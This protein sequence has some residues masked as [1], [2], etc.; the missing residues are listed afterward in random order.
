ML[1]DLIDTIETLKER[2]KEYRSYFEVAAP[3]ARTRVSLIDPLLQALEWDVANPRLVEIEPIVATGRADYALLRENGEPVLLLE[4]KRLSDTSAH[5]GQLASYVVGENMKRSVK[6]PYCGITNG[7]RWQVFDVFT[8][9]CVLDVSVDRENPR[10]CAVKLLGLW[11]P[12][13][14]EAVLEPVA[15]LTPQLVGGE[16]EGH[17][18]GPR[19]QNPIPRSPGPIS[20]SI[21]EEGN[22]QWTPLD[23]D[24]M[25][26]SRP[27]QP[28][29]IR[30]PD[31]SISKVGSWAS[32]LVTTV[33]WLFD[34]G[35]LNREEM[36]FSV[37]GTR[38]SVSVDGRHPDGTNFVRPL[39]VGETG[40]QIEGNFNGKQ[41]VRFAVD[42][43]KRY[44]RR[45]SEVSLKLRR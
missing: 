23:S 4:A 27:V 16:R 31:G 44:D 10:R 24:T 28:S 17:M 39:S 1:R 14:R 32:V 22:G 42:L 35:L 40:V 36:P 33:K 34:A 29:E 21:R 8:Q 12:T 20:R 18:R 11:Q 30:F 43:L 5:H 37:A 26:P 25:N 19:M 3:E 9:E 15:G 38:Y 41:I 7:S 6:I 2:V 45:S 13:L